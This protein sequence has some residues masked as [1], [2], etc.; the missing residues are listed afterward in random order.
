MNEIIKE[1]EP[2]LSGY[3]KELPNEQILLKYQ[4]FVTEHPNH[5]STKGR[6]VNQIAI[7]FLSQSTKFLRGCQNLSQIQKI[8][9]I[10]AKKTSFWHF[11]NRNVSKISFFQETF[12]LFGHI[13][14]ADDGLF[15]GKKNIFHHFIV[16]NC[17]KFILFSSGGGGVHLR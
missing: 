4:S 11:F 14:N 7:G 10:L 9:W 16:Q 1:L 3:G 8:W 15:R 2:C 12:F 17:L 5:E 6:L 13:C